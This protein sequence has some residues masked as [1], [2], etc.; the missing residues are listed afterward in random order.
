[1]VSLVS[2]SSV[3]HG[4]KKILQFLL[5][6]G[7]YR[8]FVNSRRYSVVFDLIFHIFA[9]TVLSQNLVYFNDLS[10]CTLHDLS[11]ELLLLPLLIE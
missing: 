3:E 6:T 7:S 5:I 10:H 11:L 4:I 8:G 9:E 1:M 2:P